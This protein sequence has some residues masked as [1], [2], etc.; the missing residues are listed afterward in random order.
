M[1]GEHVASGFLWS[2]IYCYPET[3]L[4]SVR[5]LLDLTRMKLPLG[6]LG[7][8]SIFYL[9]RVSAQIHSDD[10]LLHS[11]RKKARL[12]LRSEISKHFSVHASVFF[13]RIASNE[14]GD[15]PSYL[16]AKHL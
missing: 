8:Y 11:C 4:I 14:R 13:L 7:I 10:Y 5:N 3:I 12:L 6:Y 9:D 2:T 1:E 16:L 15:L